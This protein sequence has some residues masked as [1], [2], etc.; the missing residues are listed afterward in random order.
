M[1]GV[2]STKPDNLPWVNGRGPW[3]QG[4]MSVFGPLL[5]SA[6]PQARPMAS[7]DHDDV[8]RSRAMRAEQDGLFDIARA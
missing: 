6:L 8:Q 5:I 7:L 1:I 2:I 3:H 4:E